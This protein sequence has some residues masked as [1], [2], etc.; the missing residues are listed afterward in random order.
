MLFSRFTIGIFR[1]WQS[2]RKIVALL[3]SSHGK[4]TEAA[5]LRDGSGSAYQITLHA[6]GMYYRSS[7]T[8]SE[9]VPETMNVLHQIAFDTT[10]FTLR[11]TLDRAMEVVNG[12]MEENGSTRLPQ[13]TEMELVQS[14]FKKAK[15]AAQPGATDNLGYAQRIR[16]GFSFRSSEARCLSFIVRQYHEVDPPNCISN[17]LS[18]CVAR[19]EAEGVH[20]P[21]W[22]ED[23]RGG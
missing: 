20:H 11:R 18:C 15:K 1:R 23:H 4:H 17:L 16:E 10:I 21:R 12:W 14:M 6:E 5:V 22:P 2:E 9:Y 7:L 8:V 3:L 19:S 13:E